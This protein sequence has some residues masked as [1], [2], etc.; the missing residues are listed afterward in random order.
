MPIGGPVEH[1]R[2]TAVLV[3]GVLG[4]LCCG[5]AA[6]IAWVLGAR[7]LIEI[8]A[9]GGYYG[10]RSQARLGMALGILG[11]VAMIFMC[12]LFLVLLFR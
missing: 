6:P 8:D 12:L 3:L 2:A 10:G 4:L 1:P 7:A 9:S 5:V 11:T